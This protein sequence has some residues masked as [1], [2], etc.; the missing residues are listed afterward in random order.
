MEKKVNIGLEIHL[1]LATKSK[2]FC[3]CPNIASLTDEITYQPNTMVC[4]IC[5]GHPGTLPTLNEKAV[6]MALLLGLALNGKIQKKSYFERKNYFYPDLPKGYQISQ[7]RAPLIKEA[8]LEIFK[9][10]KL[11]TSKIRIR[12]IHLEEDTAK[13]YH[14]EDKTLIDF[15]RAGVPLLELVTEPDLHSAREAK[16]F[17]QELQRIVRTLG[18][19]QA[20]MEK[21]EMRCEVNISIS[22]N[23]KLG[24]KVEIKNLNSFKALERAIEYEIKRQTK[25][26]ESGK[27]V[28]QETRGWDEKKQKTVEQR[29][30]EEEEDYRYFPEPDLPPLEISDDL[31][32]RLK[33][34]LPE[35]PLVKRKRF[36]KKYGF[37]YFYAKILTENNQLSDFVEKVMVLIEKKLKETIEEEDLEIKKKKIAK[38][39]GDWLTRFFGLEKKFGGKFLEKIAPENFASFISFL[40]IERQIP[41]PK[42]A[43]EILKKMYKTGKSVE[44]I[45]SEESYEELS[46]EEE[47]KNIII[48]I[49]ENYPEAVADYKKGKK[50]AIKYLI[51]QVMTATKGKADPK[52]VEK[53]LKKFLSK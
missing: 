49:L 17:C 28:I 2:M 23:K 13:L 4:P 7:K 11:E 35:L 39:I 1:Q 5:L 34:Q 14:L 6:E 32:E 16:E 10:S 43:Q 19:S 36:I 15:N 48:M 50:T 26:I 29:V 41:S 25:I 30:K 20:N 53:I 33:R 37:S 27:K 45:I 3:S 8:F 47:L 18:I 24:I 52:M 46:D 22:S 42:I 44:T 21:G 31:I 38:K 51:G 9:N 12:E 40:F